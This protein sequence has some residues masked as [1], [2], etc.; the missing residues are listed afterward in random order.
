MSIRL[1]VRGLF[2]AA[3]ATTPLA[4]YN[5]PVDTAGALTVRIN[6]PAEINKTGVA[7]PVKV[8][9]DNAGAASLRGRLRVTAIDGWIVAPAGIDFD[10]AGKGSREYVFN[11]TAS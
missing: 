3:V 8:M 1:A 7:V 6:G 5:P 4:A 2:L 10:V 9:M 11:V